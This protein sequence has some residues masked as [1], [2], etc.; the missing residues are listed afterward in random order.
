M[1]SSY[2]QHYRRSGIVAEV[3]PNPQHA[4][5]TIIISYILWDTGFPLAMVVLVMYFHRLT[6]YHLPPREV[7]VSVFLPLGPIGQGSFALIQLGK[8]ALKIS[9]VTRTFEDDTGRFFYNLGNYAALVLWGYGLVWLFFALAS[10]SHSRFPF[11]MDW[12]ASPFPW[13][14]I[15]SRRQPWLKICRVRSSRCWEPSSRLWW[16]FC[17]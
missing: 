1:A 13:E 14:C 8:V 7:I 3:L 6:V 10:I 4:L 12:W 2:C 15:R 16:C 17:G 11:N 9:P 5:R